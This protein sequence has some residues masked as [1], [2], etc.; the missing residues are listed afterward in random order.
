MATP[1]TPPL[2]PLAFGH[3]AL[4]ERLVQDLSAALERPDAQSLEPSLVIGLFGEWGSGKSRLLQA[5]EQRLPRGDGERRLNVVVP[6]NA[7]RF[8]R[9]EQLLVPLLRVAQQC[10]AKALEASLAEDIR[11]NEALSDRLVLLGELAQTV[12]EHGGRQLLQSA[13][14]AHGVG[15]KL[16]EFKAE[17]ASTEAAPAG[18]ALRLDVPISTPHNLYYDFLEH[19]KAVTGRNPTGLALHRERLRNRGLGWWPRHWSQVRNALGWLGTGERPAEVDLHVNLIFLI[20][21]LDRCLPDKAVEVLEAIKLF[22]EVEGCAFVLALDEEVVERGIA[23]RYRDYALQGKEGLTPITGA[24]YLEKLVHLPVRVPRPTG[25]GAQEFLAAERPEWFAEGGRPNAFAALVAAITP[26]VP[27]KLK[28]MMSLLEMAEKLG[29]GDAQTPQRREWLALVCALQLFAPQ[30]YRYL[31]TRG[32]RLL[33]T[34]AQWREAARFRDLAALREELAQDVRNETSPGLVQDRL[35]ITRLPELCE[36]ALAN[37]SGFDLLELLARVAELDRT[38]QLP[39]THLG[40]LLAF[41][42]LKP[43]PGEAGSGMPPVPDRVAEPPPAK[44]SSAPSRPPQAASEPMAPAVVASPPSV[45]QATSEA[46]SVPTVRL[47]NERGLLEALGSGNL[48]LSRLAL[49]RE[50]MALQGQLLPESFCEQLFA[51]PLGRQLDEWI[52]AGTPKDPSHLL[53][54]ELLPHLSQRQAMQLMLRFGPSMQRAMGRP[55]WTP[56]MGDVPGTC[57]LHAPPIRQGKRYLMDTGDTAHAEAWRVPRGWIC[58][59]VKD[60]LSQSEGVS[61]TVGADETFGVHLTLTL[62]FNPGA[63]ARLRWVE[64]GSFVMGSSPGEPGRDKREGQFRTVMLSRGFWI[65]ETACTQSLWR[66]FMPDKTRQWVDRQDAYPI[67]DVRADEIDE[68]LAK[69]EA[70]L[71]GCELALPSEAEWECAAR[72]GT[73]TAWAFG[74]RVESAQVNAESRR[75]VPVASLPP[76][77][78]GLFEMHGNVG[79]LCRDFLSDTERAPNNHLD[80]EGTPGA[81]SGFHALRG[82]SHRSP[83]N[84]TRSAAVARFGRNDKRDD[85]GFR[86]IL[87]ASSP[88]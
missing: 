55:S 87:R 77:A 68:F 45:A 15:L 63:V 65:C 25:A 29:A 74:V 21:D 56:G 41:V 60:V 26:P 88:R 85:V 17:S 79:E 37:R 20:D 2:P 28:R 33:I 12:Y 24:E 71:P 9:E 52:S 72:A 36:A 16:P 13:L 57:R 61:L 43:E 80:P 51:G 34:L 86:F 78:W 8:E 22:L 73:R 48:E 35:A 70:L 4:A 5:I 50:G 46:E 44:T 84:Q 7:W 1:A 54:A 3:Q 40:A 81:Q 58:E 76:N 67:G 18:R 27:R 31:R 6:F 69:L 62:G 59:P 49:S 14:V 64:A 38:A 19:L 30:L 82:G 66:A 53:L 47:E 32:A 23:H 75:Q 39:A 10:L 83:V 11:R 42:E